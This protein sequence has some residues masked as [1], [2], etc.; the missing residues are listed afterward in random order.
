L[1]YVSCLGQIAILASAA[2]NSARSNLTG[3]DLKE[4]CA[5]WE[6]LVD[7][8]SKRFGADPNKLIKQWDLRGDGLSK[9]DKKK[10]QGFDVQGRWQVSMTP[11]PFGKIHVRRCHLNLAAPGLPRPFLWI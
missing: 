5:G 2:R 1:T 3:D 9:A 8:L 4:A 11:P 6:N 7:D 10:I